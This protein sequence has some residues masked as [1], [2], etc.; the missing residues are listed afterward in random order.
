MFH[1]TDGIAAGETLRDIVTSQVD[2]DEIYLT[3]YTPVMA[4]A[5]GPVVAVSFYTE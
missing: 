4:S 5:T 2:C 3:P 1:Y